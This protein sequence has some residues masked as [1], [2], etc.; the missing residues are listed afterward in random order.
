MKANGEYRYEAGLF[1]QGTVIAPDGTEK[2]L[3]EADT[4]QIERELVAAEIL[5]DEGK[6]K[7]VETVGE[8]K[9]AAIQMYF[10]T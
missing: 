7:F 1:G 4:A 5:F 6:V 9:S 10:L 3:S 8:M 2:V